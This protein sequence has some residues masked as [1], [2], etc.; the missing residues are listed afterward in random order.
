MVVRWC[1]VCGLRSQDGGA[2]RLGSTG[3]TPGARSTRA[4]AEPNHLLPEAARG[5]P[6]RLRGI[7]WL[8][9]G[10]VARALG[11]PWASGMKTLGIP[12]KRSG[13]QD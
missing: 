11:S 1:R 6:A 12:S 9:L 7:A 2:R 10:R 3:T 8:G 5:I 4:L 13:S